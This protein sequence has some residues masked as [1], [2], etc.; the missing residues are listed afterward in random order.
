MQ[1][2]ILITGGSG[3]IGQSLTDYLSKSFF[4]MATYHTNPIK[5]PLYIP[6][7][8]FE[9]QAV[10]ALFSQEKFDF[11]IH[12]AAN[13]NLD[14][15]EK[16]RDSVQTLN[17][18]ATELIAESCYVC[19]T[20]LIYVSTDH[21]FDGKGANSYSEDDFPSPVQEYGKTKLEGEKVALCLPNT[22]V[23]RIPIIYGISPYL[24]RNNFVENVIV[25]LKKGEI[26]YTDKTRERFFTYVMDV[27]KAL[28]L[29]I[30]KDVCGIYHLSNDEK[31]T[32]FDFAELI[33]K[34]WRLNTDL[35]KPLPEEGLALRPSLTYLNSQKLRKEIGFMPTTI[36][37]SLIDMKHLGESYD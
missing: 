14:A 11:C 20:K 27:C 15:C 4:V 9:D 22:L 12:L 10:Q 2:K 18:R 37:D 32:K 21:I 33:A 8:L 1:K 5:K 35:L 28:E 30:I 29:L 7:N 34:N 26:V 31:L 23:L 3:L 6:L 24:N 36:A 16:N 17:V 13:R 25:T 19:S